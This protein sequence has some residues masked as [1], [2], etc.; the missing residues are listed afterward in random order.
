MTAKGSLVTGGG[1]D[2]FLASTD[3]ALVTHD[4]GQTWQPL[5]PPPVLTA[6]WPSATHL[7][8]VGYAGAILRHKR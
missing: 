1:G 3:A 7:F 6:I 5:P 8:G 2:V 4:G